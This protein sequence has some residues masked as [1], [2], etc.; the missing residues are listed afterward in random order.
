MLIRAMALRNRMEEFNKR[1]RRGERESAR[2]SSSIRDA[3]GGGPRILTLEI[4]DEIDAYWGIGP[5]QIIDAMKSAG[6][7]SSIELRLNSIGG[8]IFDG[9]AIYNLLKDHP[10]PVTAIVDGLA[11][12]MGSL[13]AMAGDRIVVGEASWMMLHRVRGGIWGNAEEMI[14]FADLLDRMTGEL[15]AIYQARAGKDSE[16]VEGWIRAETWFS[17]DEAIAAGLADEKSADAERSGLAAL[18][19]IDLAAY[20]IGRAP[21]AVRAAAR[22]SRSA[23]AAEATK[24]ESQEREFPRDGARLRRARLAGLNARI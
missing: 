15:S 10:A 6:D 13:I 3:A 4:Y 7:V 19:G 23:G 21:A 16:T 22:A 20:G 17:A 2:F 12:S 9:A 8:N 11:A 5:Q 24:T 14:E 18:A 1:A